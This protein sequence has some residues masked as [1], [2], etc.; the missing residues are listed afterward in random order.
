MNKEQKVHFLLEQSIRCALTEVS[1]NG[2]TLNAESII[3]RI[4]NYYYKFEEVLVKKLAEE[5]TN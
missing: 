2:Y 5:N 4:D 1:T 3:N